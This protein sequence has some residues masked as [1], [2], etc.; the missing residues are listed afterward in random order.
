MGMEEEI[1]IPHLVGHSHTLEEETQAQYEQDYLISAFM[2]YKAMSIKDNGRISPYIPF[3]RRNLSYMKMNRLSSEKQVSS[4]I[5]RNN[6]YP[7]L[8]A[9]LPNNVNLRKRK[10]LAD[11][12][13]MLKSK[14]RKHN[15]AIVDENMEI[16][17]DDDGEE[18]DDLPP[19]PVSLR[20]PLNVRRKND[21]M[22]RCLFPKAIEY[23][24][25]LV[26]THENKKD[27]IRTP[28][29]NRS[30]LKQCGKKRM[31][32]IFCELKF[33][34][35]FHL[36]LHYNLCYP[37]LMFVPNLTSIDTKKK[38]VLLLIDIINHPKYDNIDEVSERYHS[39]N[40][41]VY[42]VFPGDKRDDMSNL[43]ID[44]TIFIRPYGRYRFVFEDAFYISKL[45]HEAS[46]QNSGRCSFSLPTTEDMPAIDI[47]IERMRFDIFDF[48]DIT[49]HCKVHMFTWNV[50]RHRLGDHRVRRIGYY[51]LAKLYIHIHWD[52]IHDWPDEHMFSLTEQRIFE[53]DT[54]G[55]TR[56]QVS[57]MQT[58]LLRRLMWKDYGD[59]SHSESVAKVVMRMEIARKT[60]KYRNALKRL[61]KRYADSL[62][63]RLARM[64]DQE[65]CDMTENDAWHLVFPEACK[66]GFFH[67]DHFIHMLLEKPADCFKRFRIPA[68][69]D[70]FE[71]PEYP[72]DE[73]M[74]AVEET[75]GTIKG[76]WGVPEESLNKKNKNKK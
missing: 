27:F 33:N 75:C 61:P 16:D 2:Q 49:Y 36:L 24:L 4:F 3:L 22:K 45:L 48:I 20:K 73:K 5:E 68:P 37:K 6:K 28:I 62:F 35:L 76:W 9:N 71:I 65:R 64:T 60:E 23:R 42:F 72:E 47:T 21:N 56:L 46:R 51:R 1:I 31:C 53:M 66:S 52:F 67:P 26:Q 69:T 74:V 58:D 70:L 39:G 54:A 63:P 34:T 8:F 43:S 14:S 50:L 30:G 57:H 17:E 13:I 7:K 15:N 44:P 59:I 55:Y 25:C 29:P 32:C 41:F 11:I 38:S 10:K 18:Q 40:Q 19:L 12:V